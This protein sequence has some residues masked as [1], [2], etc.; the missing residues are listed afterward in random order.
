MMNARILLVERNE[1][2]AQWMECALS[3]HNYQLS[4]VSDGLAALIAA[5]TFQPNL[6]ILNWLLPGLSGLALCRSLRSQDRKTQIILLNENP[7]IRDRV[8]GL[9]AGADDYL[10]T[11]F[12]QE[13]FLARVRSRLRRADSKRDSHLLE[14]EN[15]RL[16]QQTREV[17][18]GDRVIELTAKEFDLLAYLMTHP[19]QVLQ[20]QQIL[21][22][23]WNDD[24]Q[25]TSNIVEVY[26]RYLR[27][28]LEEERESRLIHTVHCIGYVL[29][30]ETSKALIRS[31]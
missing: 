3:A 10:L 20:R 29:R 8:V 27:R 15:L 1:V 31:A 30:E 28:K 12:N 6:A 9:D 24:F 2:L 13:E 7:S 4:I 14:F 18:R 22:R 5:R 19:R 11:P 17:Y 23:V 16:N 21:N 26:I 25:G